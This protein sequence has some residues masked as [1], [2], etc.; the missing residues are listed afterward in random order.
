MLCVVAPVLQVLPDADEEVSITLPP[1]QN[2]I[3][4]LALIVG[5]AAGVTFTVVTAETFVQL[6][7][8]VT[9]TV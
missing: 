8:L 4:P 7:V 2:V 1:W 3:G 6:P 9:V 5:G